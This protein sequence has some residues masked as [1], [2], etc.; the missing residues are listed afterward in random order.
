MK[1]DNST[2]IMETIGCATTTCTT[3]TQK[4]REVEMSISCCSEN[5]CHEGINRLN[6]MYYTRTLIS[7]EIQD[8]G[9]VSRE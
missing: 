7:K 1:L 4:I 5:L 9:E 6:D 2:I 3:M 8:G